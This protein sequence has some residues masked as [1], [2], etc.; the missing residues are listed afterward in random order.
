MN[1]LNL[2]IFGNNRNEGFE[3]QIRY[4]PEI[5]Y[6]NII[7]DGKDKEHK[8][9]CALEPTLSAA[10]LIGSGWSDAAYMSS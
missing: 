9:E 2:G 3:F 10:G 5:Q 4:I 6:S 1:I 7:G 8:C